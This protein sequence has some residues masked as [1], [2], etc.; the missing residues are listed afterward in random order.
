MNCKNCNSPLDAQARF[1]TN[2]GTLTTEKS[3]S[4]F[5]PTIKTTPTGQSDPNFMAQTPYQPTVQAQP[6][7]FPS[8][9][10]AQPSIYPQANNQQVPPVQ[11]ATDPQA[12]G[13]YTPYPSNPQANNA[14]SFAPS[15]WQPQYNLSTATASPS[16]KT[17]KGRRR[18]NVWLRL[19][20]TLIILFG[21]LA[22]V[23][24]LAVRPYIHNIA[25]TE[26]N[27]AL[28]EAINQIQPL[29]AQLPPG[30]TRQ[31]NEAGLENLIKLNI[32]PSGPV[33]NPVV[34]ID[35]QGIRL[36]LDIYTFHNTFSLLPGLDA[37][38]NLVAN[39]VQVNG[40][41]S[42]VMSSDELSSLI[43]QYLTRA[44]KKLNHPLT[45]LQLQPGVLTITFQ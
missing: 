12:A 43:N 19:F 35:Q 22:A 17:R 42:L 40:V 5:E 18:G 2:C 27:T 11:T 9:V 30:T 29:P 32:A 10:Q 31:I 37:H 13:R 16:P 33:Q 4:A 1:C 41:A 26:L 36:E 8:T 15:S 25:E 45:S 34:H 6:P 23:W 44:M 24:F 7:A 14:T 28:S 3:P 20:T 21:I 38:G 39:N